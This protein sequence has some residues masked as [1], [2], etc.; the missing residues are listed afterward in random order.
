MSP[1]EEYAQHGWQLCSVDR[2]TKGP[3]YPSWNERPIPA[4]AVA[5]MDG[6]GLLHALSG[7]CAIDVDDLELARPWLLEEGVDIDALLNAPSAVRIDSGRPNR[8]K[9]IYALKRPLRT[10]K[11]KGSGLELRCATADGKSVQDVVPPSFHPD[12]KKPYRWL[13]PEPMLG[14]WRN[15][16]PLP[17]GILAVWRKLTAGGAVPAVP[18]GTVAHKAG[19]VDLAALRKAAFAHDPNCEH[20]EW[21]KVGAQLNDGTSGAQ[22]G[23]DI[24]NDWSKTATR[25]CYSKKGVSAYPGEDALLVRYKSFSS[26]GGKRVA[27]G[28]ALAAELP[29]TADEFPIVDENEE[30]TVDSTSDLLKKAAKAHVEKAIG[31]LEKRL[32]FVIDMA[33]Y[34]DAER[35]KIIPTD[36]AI[37]HMFTCTMPRG[38]TGARMNPVRILKESANK[39]WVDTLAFHPGEGTIF[40]DGDE[41]YANTYRNRLAKPLEPT[42][43]ERERIDWL[44]DRIDDE[45]FRKW[46]RQFLAH[47]VQKPGIKV[48]SAPLIWSGE[49][50]NGK[51]TLL[52]MVPSLLVGQKYSRE[53][54]SSQLNDMFNGF[55]LDAWHVN[56]TEFRA[57]TRGEREAVSKK[58]E[59]WIADDYVTVRPM[60][61]AAYTMPNHFF[62]TATSNADDAASITNQDRKWAIHEL[63]AKQ[64]TESEQDWMYTQFLLT[65]RAAGVLRQYFLEVPLDGFVASAKAPNTAARQEMVGASATPDFEIL[66]IAMEEQSGI[67]ERDIV[68]THEAT[69]FVHKNSTAR[70][71]I[72]RVGKILAGAPF[73]GEVIHFRAGQ[74]TFRGMLLRNKA[75]WRGAVGLDIMAHIQGEDIDITN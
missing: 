47:I 64:F 68:L 13:Y 6:A 25:E 53:V 31:N 12:T 52:R 15:P 30:I 73:N 35:H 28:A 54:T 67:F 10:V 36:N 45:V 65:K 2:G 34:F 21:L 16:P 57:G 62:L 41:A 74:K 19:G 23:F 37:E 33:K 63:K 27:S 50:G 17:P 5:G 4:D 58:V 42:P 49:Q 46:L 55:L 20:D 3:T 72:H 26:G 29:A 40:R 22:E 66:Q 56:L 14:D 51:T 7:T 8:A 38:K 39:Q 71:S 60:H 61:A 75:R 9:L 32:I 59:P 24:W 43:A 18:A 1:F 48:K 44:F 11:P 69:S 70:P